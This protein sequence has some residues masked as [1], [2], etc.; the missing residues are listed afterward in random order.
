MTQDIDDV[1]EGDRILDAADGEWHGVTRIERETGSIFL[2][3][4]GVMGVDDIADLVLPSE[5]VPEAA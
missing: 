1:Q 2:S 3:S 4:G 5:A